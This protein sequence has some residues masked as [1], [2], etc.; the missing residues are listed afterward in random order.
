[1]DVETICGSQHVDIVTGL[2]RCLGKVGLINPEQK[3]E[4][5]CAGKDDASAAKPA[6]AIG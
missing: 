3:L 1:L 5:Y 4:A 2:L 6:V